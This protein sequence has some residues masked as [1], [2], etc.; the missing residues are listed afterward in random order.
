MGVSDQNMT[1]LD[2]TL[3]GDFGFDPLGMSDPEGAGGFVNPQWLAYSEV[4][5]GRWTMLGVAGI[6]APEVL[7]GAGI[8]PADTGLVWFKSGAI[9][10]QGTFDYWADPTTI[11]WVNMCLMNFAEI[12]RGQDYWYPGSQAET[13][14]MGWEK[15]FAGSG[16]PAYPGGKYFNFA[17]LGKDDMA[18][19]QKKEIKNGRLA[20]MAFLGCVVQAAATG[21]GPFKN[22]CDHIADP[23]GAN[24]LVNF[25]NIGGGA[26]PF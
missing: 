7:G 24:M 16:N 10:P 18:K 8:I 19:M 12:K 22:I 3:P 17:N 1:Y 6:V 14:L 13:P 2:G 21:E 20:M 4:I 26:S 5:H 11:F 15:G 25:S 9:P 23:F